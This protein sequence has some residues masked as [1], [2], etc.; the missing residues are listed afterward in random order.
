MIYREA[1]RGQ[2]QREKESITVRLHRAFEH[3]RHWNEQMVEC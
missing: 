1:H 3:I 2:E